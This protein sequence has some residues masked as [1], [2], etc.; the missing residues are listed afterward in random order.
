MRGV[1]SVANEGGCGARQ[2]RQS[3]FAESVVERPQGRADIGPETDWIVVMLIQRHPRR[4]ELAARDPHADQGGFPESGRRAEEAD[5]LRQTHVQT[6]QQMLAWKDTRRQA[7]GHQLGMKQARRLR[8]HRFNQ[9]RGK[10]Q[11]TPQF[12]H[13]FIIKK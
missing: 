13:D 2:H 12:N 11:G 4:G 7:W 5:F 9:A 8:R 10:M 1:S 6:G 3:G